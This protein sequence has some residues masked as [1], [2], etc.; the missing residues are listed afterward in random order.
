V[1]TNINGALAPSRGSK[2]HISHLSTLIRR[3]SNRINE[4]KV[5][6]GPGLYGRES[7]GEYFLNHFKH[8]YQSTDP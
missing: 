6:D 1:E 3:Q 4:I 7:I 8:I 2:F 5:D